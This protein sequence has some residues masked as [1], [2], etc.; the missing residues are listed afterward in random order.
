MKKNLPKAVLAHVM[1]SWREKT[2]LQYGVYHRKW[3]TF[4]VL[5]GLDPLKPTL[6]EGLLFL[7]SLFDSGLN[8]S[9]LNSARS[10]LS[11]ILPHFDDCSFGT[12]PLVLRVLRS[13]YNKRPPQARYSHMW[14]T[15]LVIDYLREKTPLMSLSLKDITLKFC[16]LFLLATCS[17]QQRLCGLKRS[18]IKIQQNGTV[19]I[20][21]DSVQKHSSRGKSLEVLT[22]KP[23]PGDRSVCVVNN[24]LH[25][26]LRTK[27]VSNAKDFLLCSYVPPYNRVGTQTVSRWIKALMKEAGVDTLVFKPHSTRGASASKLANLGT[28]LHEILKRGSWSQESSFKHFYL[29]EIK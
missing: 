22:L 26:M 20:T 7:V 29:R 19:D 10:A 9:S 27:E 13:F 16:M 21:I 4:C 11:C 2:K 23:F 17:R 28:P 6:N 25:Y 1:D 24:L 14:D 18:N 15:D 8:Y 5:K 3:N 12:H